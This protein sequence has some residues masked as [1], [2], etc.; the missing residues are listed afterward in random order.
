[1]EACPAKIVKYLDPFSRYRYTPRRAISPSVHSS[2]AISPSRLSGERSLFLSDVTI[3]IVD[4][5]IPDD[6]GRH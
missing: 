3:E 2:I 5:E 4:L 6:L 1:M